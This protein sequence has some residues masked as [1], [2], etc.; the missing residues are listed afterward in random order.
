MFVQ[1][2]EENRII[3]TAEYDCFPDDTI[4]VEFDFP[5]D[6][7]FGVQYDHKI[8]DGKLIE[9]ESVET[10]AQREENVSSKDRERFLSEAPNTI[11]E[12]DD[13]ICALY[14][15]NLALKSAANDVDDAVCYLYEQLTR[16]DQA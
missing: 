1:L 16:G 9:S 12:Q 10:K 6:F 7:D 15:E 8:I 14:E 13:A 11:N 5:E 4:V 2:N 3:G